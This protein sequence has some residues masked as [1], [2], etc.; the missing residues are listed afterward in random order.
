MILNYIQCWGTS[1]RNTWNDYYQIGII[2]LNHMI[3]CEL[4][5][6]DWNTWNYITVSKQ[7]IIIK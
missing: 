7:M 3:Q 6:L 2:I 5:V 1:S 4:L